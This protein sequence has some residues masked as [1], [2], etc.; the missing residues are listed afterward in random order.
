MWTWLLPFE[1]FWMGL[2][3]GERTNISMYGCLQCWIIQQSHHTIMKDHGLN[4]FDFY[5]DN[6]LNYSFLK[7]F[8]ER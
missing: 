8:L 1:L 7:C 5:S 2:R 6:K 3:G 4:Q